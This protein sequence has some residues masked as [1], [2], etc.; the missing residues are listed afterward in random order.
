MYCSGVVKPCNMS[1]SVKWATSW[2]NQQ[3]KCA[4][5]EDSDQPWH[6]PSLIRV[7]AEPGHPP[8]LIRVFAV[9]VKKAWVLSYP[10]SAQ[11]RL[12]S[13][14]GHF[15]GF[16]MS[17]LK[18]IMYRKSIPKYVFWP[19]KDDSRIQQCMPVKFLFKNWNHYFEVSSSDEKHQLS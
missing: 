14:W 15:V 11:R 9:H 8:S 18:W 3:N 4:P 17:R 7:L 12:W 10:F 1:F 2:Q 13:D 6:L 19:Q 5:S 16:V